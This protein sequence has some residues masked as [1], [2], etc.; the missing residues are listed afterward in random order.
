MVED[1]RELYES[2]VKPGLVKKIVSSSSFLLNHSYD[3]ACHDNHALDELK[4]KGFVMLPKHHRKLDI[5]LTGIFLQETIRR[6]GHYI[7]KQSLPRFLEYVGGMPIYR[8]KEMKKMMKKL[9]KKFG[10]SEARRIMVPYAKQNNDALESNLVD[11]LVQ[12]HIVVLYPEA[13]RNDIPEFEVRIPV[14]KNL[15]RL[16]EKYYSRTGKQ[17][18]FVPLSIEYSHYGRFRSEILLNVAEPMLAENQTPKQFGEL[19]KQ[20]IDSAR[21]LV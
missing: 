8:E 17:I 4:Q 6:Y 7:M 10:E 20:R 1:S 21:R 18:P 2:R 15:L 13:A 3:I 14:M 16:N 12:D 9:T 11:L 19:L 5:I